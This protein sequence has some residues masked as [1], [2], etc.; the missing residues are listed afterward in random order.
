[1]SELFDIKIDN[2]IKNKLDCGY[3]CTIKE[4]RK[5]QKFFEKAF[6]RVFED[7]TDHELEKRIEKKRRN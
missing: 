6:G 2:I 3:E 1:M 7:I 4:V 5:T